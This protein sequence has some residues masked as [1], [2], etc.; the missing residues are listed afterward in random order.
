MFQ[1]DVRGRETQLASHAVAMH[2][3][4]ADAVGTS[5]VFARHAYLPGCQR[6]TYRRAGDAH[7]VVQHAVYCL[8]RKAALRADLFH[9][10]KIACPAAAESEIVADQHELRMQFLMQGMDEIRRRL[11][12]K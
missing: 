7:P 2:H 10:R 3:A 11:L 9:Q 4:P 8:Y 6:R 5:Q 1:L 12:R